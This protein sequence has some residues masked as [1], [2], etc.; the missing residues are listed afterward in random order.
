MELDSDLM[1]IYGKSG[2]DDLSIV[3]ELHEARCFR[4]LHIE[5]A[6]IGSSLEILHVVFFPHPNF[7]LPIF[8]VDLVAVS[9]V[10]TAAIVD[11]SPVS[12]KLP[13][14]IENELAKI[15]WPSF[16]RVRPLPDWG[17][18]FSSYAQFIKPLTN[19][20]NQLFIS[21]TSKFL[22]ILISYSE[23][24]ASEDINSKATIERFNSQR[25]YCLQQKRNDKTRSVLSRA[26]SPDW[27]NR[28]IDMVLFDPPI[29]L[30]F[31]GK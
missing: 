9:G 27:A 26:F 4:K 22:D 15:E 18:I 31:K 29:N 8:G 10:V 7:D 20:E 2:L 1:N 5:T 17:D 11:L 24:I 13:L 23:I 14:F 28:Y 25:Y 12:N 3:N 21:I 16:E 19:K 30:I 6:L